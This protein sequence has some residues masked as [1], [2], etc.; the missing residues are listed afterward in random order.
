VNLTSHFRYLRLTDNLIGF[1]DGRVEGHSFSSEPNWV[2]EGALSLGICS[3]ALIDGDEAV[4]YDTHVSPEH[5]QKIRQTLERLGAKKICVVLSHWHLDHV[6]GT[7]AF[8]DCAIIANSRTASL[9][10]EHKLAI[11]NGTHHGPPA[12]SPLILPTETFEGQMELQCGKLALE[13]IEMNIHSSDATVLLMPNEKLL[14]AGD[15]LE[16]TITYVAEPGRLRDHLPE[17]DRMFGFDIESIFPNHG[18]PVIIE[19]GGYR[20]TLIRAT[21]QYIRTLLRCATD[22]QLRAKPLQELIAGPLQAGWVSYFPPYENVHR[23]NLAAVML[24]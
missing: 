1:Y 19:N 9:L 6:A 10:S 24:Q 11:E 15:T 3:Y 14:L 16:D 22:D 21:Q 20:K 23:D 7:S 5:G 18:D 2:D 13:L 8:S 4:V 12:I 17:L